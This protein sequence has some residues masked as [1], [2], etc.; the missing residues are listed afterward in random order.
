MGTVNILEAIRLTDSVK[1]GIMI[2]TDK[3]YEN[4]EWMWPYREHEAIGGY[5]P[6]S[7][8]KGACELIISS[9]R[10]SFYYTNIQ[11]MVNPL[12]LHVQEMLLVEET[13]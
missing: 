6:Y 4:K 7:S 12:P 5:D 2:T 13:S 11:N 9:Y 10:N 3:V 1:T 8:S